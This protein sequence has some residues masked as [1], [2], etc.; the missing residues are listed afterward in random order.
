MLTGLEQGRACP[1]TVKGSITA[2]VIIGLVALVGAIRLAK[3][4]S[5]WA[6]HR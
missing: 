5:W 4:G 6:V 2:T 1:T 3:P